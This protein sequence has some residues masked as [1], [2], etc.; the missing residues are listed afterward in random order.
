[1]RR[2]INCTASQK[3]QQ[4][5][6]IFTDK[7][8]YRPRD[9][10]T[11]CPLNQNARI[12]RGLLHRKRES[13]TYLPFP[14]LKRM[15]L[16]ALFRHKTRE[17]GC[18]KIKQLLLHRQQCQMQKGENV[19]VVTQLLTYAIC[20]LIIKLTLIHFYLPNICNAVPCSPVYFVFTS[21]IPNVNIIHALEMAI[22][23]LTE[24]M[25]YQATDQ[26]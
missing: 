23:N 17:T 1:M 19:C 21:K 22:V 6:D 10:K 14:S 4:M 9:C 13:E 8:T 5:P 3:K 18:N 11:L 24:A 7:E 12:Y 15:K 16:L 25:S 26:W 20:S 2:T